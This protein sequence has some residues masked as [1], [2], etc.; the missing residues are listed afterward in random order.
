M[1]VEIRARRVRATLAQHRGAPIPSGAIRLIMRCI[2]PVV[3]AALIL[4]CASHRSQQLSPV[5][6]IGRTELI[7]VNSALTIVDSVA[8]AHLQDVRS[9]ALPDNCAGRQEGDTCYRI[10]GEVA[11]EAGV[12][13]ERATEHAIALKNEFPS[14]Y[15][16]RELDDARQQLREC[17][18]N[19][20][21][22][23]GELISY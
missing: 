12:G 7:C 17:R 5:A 21:D 10:Q 6:N 4:G 13:I 23:Y 1:S 3:A 20:H 11:V 19:A 8:A 16:L 22:Y 9:S 15:E 14:A 2:L 18:T